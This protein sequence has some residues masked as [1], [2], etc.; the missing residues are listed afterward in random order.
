MANVLKRITNRAKQLQKQHPRMQWKDLVRMAAKDI[1]KKK[2]AAKKKSSPRKKKKFRR[3]SGIG[4]QSKTH[5]DKN[6][7][8]DVNISI[9]SVSS[10]MSDAKKILNGRLDRLVLKRYKAKKKTGKGGK[11][12]LSKDISKVKRQINLIGKI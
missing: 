2:P 12:Q 7:N 9:G 4:M 1:R 6:R 5:V 8:R 10:I 3:V 11:K